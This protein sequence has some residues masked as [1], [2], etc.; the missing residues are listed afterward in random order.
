MAAPEFV[1]TSPTAPKHYTSPPARAGAGSAVR[2]G[3]TFG[4]QPSGGGRLGSQGPD[5]GFV[6]KLVTVFEDKL[7][8]EDGEYKGDVNAGCVG[9]ALKRAS[10]F[11]RAPVVHDLR[12][13]YMLFGFLDESPAADLVAFRKEAFG[14]VHYSFHYFERRAIVDMVADEVLTQTPD[15]VASR[16][17]ADWRD[18]IGR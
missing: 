18:Q 9:V 7:Q 11:H 8:L 12:I 3:E 4:A 1:P 16:Y 10:L 5:Q 2:P 14:E 6:W 13:A 15:Q 17:N